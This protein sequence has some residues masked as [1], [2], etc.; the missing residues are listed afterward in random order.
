M[1]SETLLSR[2][3]LANGLILELW[4]QSRPVAGDRWLVRLE[5]RIAV[6]V[7]PATLPPDLQP[8]AAEVREA[9]GEEIIFSQVDERNVIAAAAMPE[10]LQDMQD[11]AL[12][13]AADYFGR[14]EFAA[15]FI[16]KRF[17]EH[18]ARQLWQQAAAAKG[19][20]P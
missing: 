9:L 16:R 19:L 20:T 11:R 12:A 7:A 3:P 5:A 1:N 2:Q 4:N 17:R 15:G 10:I 18:R 8:R 6:P 14:P 13:L